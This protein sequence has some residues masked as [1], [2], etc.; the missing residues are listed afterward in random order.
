MNA[1]KRKL[2]HGRASRA[3]EKN[4][5]KNTKLKEEAAFAKVFASV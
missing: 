1:I 5:S 2:Q 4:Q 3:E